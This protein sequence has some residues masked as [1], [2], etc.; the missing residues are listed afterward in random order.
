MDDSSWRECPTHK[1][2]YEHNFGLFILSS[3]TLSIFGAGIVYFFADADISQVTGIEYQAKY[4][5][6]PLSVFITIFSYIAS[7][8]CPECE[9]ERVA[10][11]EIQVQENRHEKPKEKKSETLKCKWCGREYPKES[12]VSRIT[13]AGAIGTVF[14]PITSGLSLLAIPFIAQDPT[15]CPYSDCH[16]HHKV[17]K[18]PGILRSLSFADY[19]WINLEWNEFDSIISLHERWS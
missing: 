18:P 16:G 13:T 12:L 14:A 11:Q 10:N 6:L 7:Y 8:E 19:T 2:E 9:A 15:Q 5:V 3:V 1:V 17:L 4:A